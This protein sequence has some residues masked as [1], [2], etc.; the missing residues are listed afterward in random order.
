MTEMTE[1]LIVFT[2]ND[3]DALGCML[4]IQFKFPDVPKEY[5]HTN[6][7]NIDAIVTE[8][9]RYVQQTGSKHILIVDVSFGD[10][11]AALQKLYD[12]GAKITHIDHHLY[13]ENFWADFP[14]MKV[15]WS[16]EKSATLL[17]NDYFGNTGKNANLDRVSELI[18][19]YDIWQVKKGRHFAIAQDINDYFWSK[20]KTEGLT[21]EQLMNQFINAGWKLPPDYQGLVQ[22]IKE[23]Y[24]KEIADYEARGL[25]NRAGE[26]TLCF[27][28]DWF[29]HVLVKEMANGKNFV[30]GLN[31]YGIIRCRINEDAPYTDEQKNA[32]RKELA[33]TATIGHTNAFTYKIPD[34]VNFDKLMAEAQRVAGAIER[35]CV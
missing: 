13:P 2:H 3:L 29:N 31:S 27:I 1:K 11:K 28:P 32:L 12:T 21:I 17:C 33:G 18:D 34:P 7:A 15:H 26:I 22:S 9:E 23:G 4:N 6:Y 8:I 14:D 35:H 19:V 5:F 30:I 24:T 16:K 25:I 20:V 10:N